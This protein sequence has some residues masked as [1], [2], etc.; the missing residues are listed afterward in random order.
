MLVTAF[1]VIKTGEAKA[2]TTNVQKTTTI[3]LSMARTAPQRDR[4]A[5]LQ[6]WIIHMFMYVCKQSSAVICIHTHTYKHM[7][8]KITKTHNCH[9]TKYFTYIYADKTTLTTSTHTHTLT[10]IYLINT[11]AQRNELKINLTHA[12]QA[13]A[14]QQAA[15]SYCQTVSWASGES[16]KRPTE[17]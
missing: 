7:K 13:A 5:M 14:S 9:K 3:A 1:N 2:K 11:R 17:M 16:T 15:A 10:H 6:S 8:Y 12:K 4:S